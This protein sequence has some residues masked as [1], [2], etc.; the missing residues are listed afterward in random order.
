MLVRPKA[1]AGPTGGLYQV[2]PLITE[3]PHAYLVWDGDQ[4]VWLPKTE[5]EYDACDDD[6]EH[7]YELTVLC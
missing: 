5:Y 7:E 3:C 1:L 4:S 2:Y 6:D